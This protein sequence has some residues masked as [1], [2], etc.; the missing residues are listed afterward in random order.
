MLFKSRMN[1]V[2]TEELYL[3][4]LSNFELIRDILGY[5]PY[6]SKCGGPMWEINKLNIDRCIR[7]LDSE[8]LVELINKMNGQHSKRALWYLVDDNLKPAILR[9]LDRKTIRSIFMGIEYHDIILYLK[10]QKSDDIEYICSLLPKALLIIIRNCKFSLKNV[11][12]HL[13]ENN[14]EH[15]ISHIISLELL[16]RDSTTWGILICFFCFFYMVIKYVT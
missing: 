14:L 15:K 5:H 10:K 8:K 16:L 2:D 9:K 12:S 13:K 4:F 1:Y 3:L 11:E 7:S 6:V